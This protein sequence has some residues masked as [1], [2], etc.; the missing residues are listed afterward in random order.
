MTAQD[1]MKMNHLDAEKK[2]KEKDE[3]ERKQ[4]V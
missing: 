1:D 2:D 4:E 3:N